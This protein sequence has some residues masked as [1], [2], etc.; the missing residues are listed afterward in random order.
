MSD[1]MELG[2]VDVENIAHLGRRIS[3]RRR[4][5]FSVFASKFLYAIFAEK[6]LSGFE[7]FA[8]LVR[9]IGLRNGH[10]CDVVGIAPCSMGSGGDA[11]TNGGNVFGDRHWIADC[12]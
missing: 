4:G 12:K 2:F 7:R 5:E 8:N 10:Q 1:E 3:W 6:A 9:G 11:N